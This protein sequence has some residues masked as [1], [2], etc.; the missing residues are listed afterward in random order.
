MS[1]NPISKEPELPARCGAM[2]PKKGRMMRIQLVWRGFLLLA[3]A[4]AAVASPGP[5]SVQAAAGPEAVVHWNGIAVRAIV[6]PAALGGAGQPPGHALITL[7]YVQAAVYNA[8]MAIEGGYR[9]YHSKL[10]RR[11]GASVDAAVAAAA[12]DVLVYY[13]PAT[14]DATVEAEYANALAAIADGQSKTEGIALGQAAATEIIMLR[15]GDGYLANVAV[16]LPS[17]GPGVWTLPPVPLTPWV[18]DMRPFLMRSD[19]QFRPGPPPR[20]KTN[21][22]AQDY[23]E[24]MAIGRNTSA[25]RTAAQTDAAWFWTDHPARQWNTLFADL[26]SARGLDA[27]GAARLYAMGNMVSA[28]AV[29]ACWDA[30]Y[31]YLFWRPVHAI[32]AGETDGNPHTAGDP[33]WA[34]LVTNPPHPEYP[35]GHGC[36]TSALASILTKFLG[37]NKI[38]VDIKSTAAGVV[39]TTRHFATAQALRQEIIDARV[40]SGIHFRY[41][42]EVGAAIGQAVAAYSLSHNFGPVR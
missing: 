5:V 10:G 15:Q 6:N 38:E 20:L 13:L 22:W 2:A 1:N 37:T 21:R 34:P 14:Q 40:W 25:V 17:P 7:G 3:V 30:K 39:Q 12:R 27:A 28:D 29:I 18:G 41:S 36:V 31:H 42:D 26:V 24:V 11:P 16:N 4:L 33:A 35:S 32:A 23:N 8:V 19:S 9:P